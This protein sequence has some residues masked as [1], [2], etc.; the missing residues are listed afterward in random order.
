MARCSFCKNL[1]D[2]GT[3]KIYVKIDGK[4]LHFC[5]NKCEKNM[6]KLGRKPRLTEWTL[7]YDEL[8]KSGKNA[9]EQ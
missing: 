2:K 1:I 6:I 3:G 5:S 9:K 7:E 4:V 8:K